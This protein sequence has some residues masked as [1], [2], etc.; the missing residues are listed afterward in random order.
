MTEKYEYC[1]TPED[2]KDHLVLFAGY[3]TSWTRLHS[4]ILEVKPGIGPQNES[5]ESVQP[6][7]ICRLYTVNRQV[8]HQSIS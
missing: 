6:S 3:I 7:I 2:Y 8:S 1:S 4:T 5:F